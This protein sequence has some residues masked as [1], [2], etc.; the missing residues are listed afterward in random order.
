MSLPN[1]IC[2][3]YGLSQYSNG[4]VCPKRDQ[5]AR[6]VE[7]EQGGHTPHAGRLCYTSEYNNMIPL[8][9]ANVPER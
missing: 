3:C 6:Y 7:R 2:R 4:P 1:D 8:E 5:C 9:A